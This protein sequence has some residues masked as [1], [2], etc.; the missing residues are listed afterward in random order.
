LRTVLQAVEREREKTEWDRTDTRSQM[1]EMARHD[2]RGAPSG[3]W[4]QTINAERR[5]IDETRTD[6][7]GDGLGRNEG[8][9]TRTDPAQQ[10]L[11]RL[12]ELQREADERN[13]RDRD[14]RDR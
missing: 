3:E 9:T 6:E 7:R 11:P 5:S 12:E 14:E 10:R 8:D 13:E 2:E 1:S 4:R